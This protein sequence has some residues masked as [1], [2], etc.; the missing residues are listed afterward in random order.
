MSDNTSTMRPLRNERANRIG[1]M[2]W[3]GPV[4]VALVAVALIG[5]GCSSDD[6]ADV[7]TSSESPAETPTT[8]APEPAPTTE[9]P[10]AEPADDAARAA[11]AD[12]L[13]AM[14]MA[15]DPENEFFGPG[16]LFP[17]SE[18]RCFAEAAVED[19]G[20]EQVA[21]MAMPFGAAPESGE[22]LPPDGPDVAQILELWRPCVDSHQHIRALLEAGSGA[23]LAACVADAASE[24]LAWAV[25]VEPFLGG[26]QGLSVETEAE[27][28]QLL[29]DCGVANLQ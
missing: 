6:D 1:R 24:E 25:A 7:V 28:V 26:G 21:A 13:V 18:L 4:V 12:N 22:E 8:E 16:G 14:F 11:A 15:I 9:A 10:A 23:E 29:D 2:R 27:Y 3:L 19:F 17:E 20:P 5:A